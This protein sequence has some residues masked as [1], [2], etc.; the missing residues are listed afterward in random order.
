MLFCFNDAW[1]RKGTIFEGFKPEHRGKTRFQLHIYHTFGVTI[2]I[3]LSLAET[4]NN[5]LAGWTRGHVFDGKIGISKV[6]IQWQSRDATK[7]ISCLKVLLLLGYLS[8]YWPIGLNYLH[9]SVVCVY[10]RVMHLVQFGNSGIA[11]YYEYWEKGFLRSQ[12]PQPHS[13]K[14]TETKFKTYI[15][16][17]TTRAI[18]SSLTM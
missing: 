18:A 15:F 1:K 11:A 9:I 17:G 2:G 8:T 5:D 6:M 4:T 3:C 14:T 13:T 12:F 16:E 7:Q 10:A